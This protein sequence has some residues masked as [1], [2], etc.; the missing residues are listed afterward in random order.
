MRGLMFVLTLCHLLYAGLSHGAERYQDVVVADPF[1]ELHTGPGRGYPVTQVVARGDSVDVL[2]RRTEWF[3]VRTDRDVR[4]WVNR[5]Q[6]ERTLTDSG[7]ATR[8]RDV[9]VEDYLRRRLEFGLAGGQVDGDPAM[10]A[11]VGYVINRNVITEFALSRVTGEFSS[12]TLWNV[13]V[14]SQ[15]LPD[16]RFLPFFTIGVGQFYNE[17]RGTLVNAESTDSVAFNA[18]LGVRTYLTR[19]FVARLDFKSYAVLIDDD[20]TDS[21][22]EWTLGLSFFF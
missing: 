13:N 18:G 19:R 10:V 4:G 17:P 7:V 3:K 20:R 11:R 15:P 14:I 5:D 12:S 6:L 8:F 1:I 16:W 9:L 21:L 22:N 2:F